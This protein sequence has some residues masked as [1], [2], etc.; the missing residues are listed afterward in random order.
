[1]AATQS[2]LIDDN[3]TVNY[4]WA[5]DRWNESSRVFHVKREQSNRLTFHEEDNG[6]GIIDDFVTGNRK[7]KRPDDSRKT[8]HRKQLTPFSER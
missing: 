2:A 3:V 6:L 7:P 5:D 4:S 8:K 1:M